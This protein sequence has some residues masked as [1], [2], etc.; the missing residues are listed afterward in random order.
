MISEASGLIWRNESSQTTRI[1]DKLREESVNRSPEQLNVLKWTRERLVNVALPQA[2]TDLS[3]A[4]R[5]CS[6]LNDQVVFRKKTVGYLADVKF[7]FAPFD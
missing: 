2:D 3:D 4:K 1:Q 7:L 6:P 5:Y